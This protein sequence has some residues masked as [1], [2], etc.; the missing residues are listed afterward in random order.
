M[1][2]TPIL[3][4]MAAGGMYSRLQTAQFGSSYYDLYDK[5]AKAGGQTRLWRLFSYQI[6]RLI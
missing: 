2:G 5:S 3:I 4:Q 1:I 6:T